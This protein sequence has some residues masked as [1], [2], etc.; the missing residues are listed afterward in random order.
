MPAKSG[1]GRKSVRVKT[2]MKKM[3]SQRKSQSPA[4]RPT[5][6]GFSVEEELGLRLRK[7][8]KLR[9]KDSLEE[10]NFDFIS[11]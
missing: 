10:N 9:K 3:I 6:A 11:I 2:R 1:K 4:P 8:I 5:E 7:K